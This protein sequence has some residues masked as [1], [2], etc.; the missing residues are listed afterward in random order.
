MV[1]A[2]VETAL[3]LNT[4]LPSYSLWSGHNPPHHRIIILMLKQAC[5]STVLK[6]PHPL[7]NISSFASFLGTTT[8]A[9]LPL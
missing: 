2:L 4:P 9:S 3:C 1:E 5:A 6:Q 7:R 8:T